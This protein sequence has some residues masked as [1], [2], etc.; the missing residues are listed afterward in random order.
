MADFCQQCSTALFGDD[1][2]DLAG[3]CKAGEVVHVICEGCGHTHV[4]YQGKCVNPH[5]L[6]SHGEKP[7]GQS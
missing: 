1:Y 2:R 7:N 3:L 6:N 5:C 4:D